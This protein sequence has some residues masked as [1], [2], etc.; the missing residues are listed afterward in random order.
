MPF[1]VNVIQNVNSWGNIRFWNPL[2]YLI[3]FQVQILIQNVSEG[4]IYVFDIFENNILQ[5]NSL[6]LLKLSSIIKPRKSPENSHPDFVYSNTPLQTISLDKVSQKFGFSSLNFAQR[7]FGLSFKNFCAI[8][9]KFDLLPVS[10][11]ISGFHK[12]I[13]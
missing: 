12:L 6:Q 1:T 13:S 9:L 5:K 10:W 7:F 2:D 8:F 3:G 11:S 4:R